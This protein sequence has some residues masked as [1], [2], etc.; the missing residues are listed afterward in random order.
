MNRGEVIDEIAY[1]LGNRTDLR[2]RIID[3]MDQAQRY[4]LE[5]QTVLPWF[6]ISE[7][8]AT[9]TTPDEPRLE[10][11]HG[12]LRE[13]EEGAV[14][15]WAEPEDDSGKPWVEL[16]K[17]PHDKLRSALGEDNV[18]PWKGKPTHYALI[19]KYFLLAPV[20]D[21][22]YRIYTRAY[23]EELLPSELASDSKTNG[24][25]EYEA[26]LLVAET[27][28]RMG[29]HLQFTSTQMQEFRNDRTEARQQYW[30]T[31]EARTHANLRY[32]MGIARGN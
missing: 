22:V 12:F 18:M 11:P 5:R 10:V 30:T 16:V 19:G 1:R 14:W 15:R 24:W 28:V 17:Q 21:A 8:L 26:E 6:L 2:N 13:V 3:S 29:R 4:V 27:V 25:M 31:H 20:P 32:R 7:N 23:Q 9:D